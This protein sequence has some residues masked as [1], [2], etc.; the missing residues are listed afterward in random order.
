MHA[1]TITVI[2]DELHCIPILILLSG[3]CGS[4]FQPGDVHVLRGLRKVRELLA[5][6]KERESKYIIS[7]RIRR[8]SLN[9]SQLIHSSFSLII[10]MQKGKEGKKFLSLIIR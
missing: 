5:R 4:L 2:A 7:H 10:N 1:G 9:L 6:E 8:T 3:Q